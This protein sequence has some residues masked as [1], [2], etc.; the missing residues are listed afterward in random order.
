MRKFIR[1][2]NTIKYLKAKQIFYRIYYLFRNRFVSILSPSLKPVKN[3]KASN[4]DAHTWID[5][6]ETF[7]APS[8]FTFIGLSHTFAQ[9]KIDWNYHDLGK[10]WNYNLTYFDFLLQKS[11]TKEQGLKL[12]K[13]FMHY[14]ESIRGKKMPFPISLRTV[15]FIKFLCKYQ[16]QDQ[17]IEDFVYAEYRVLLQNIEYHILGNHLLENGFSLL[18][19]AYYFHDEQLYRHATNILYEELDEQILEDGAHFE[20]SPMYHQIMLHRLLDIINLLE[21]NKWKEDNLLKFLKEKASSML[22]WL[23]VISYRNGDLPRLNDT[24]E[25]IAPNNVVL[26]KY[27]KDLHISWQKSQLGA[28]G[29]RKRERDR[30]ECLVDI[31]NIGPDYI[32]GHA[33]SDIGHFELYIDGSPLLVDTGL[34]TYE[35][36]SIREYE[37]SAFAHN[38]VVIN[39]K[40]QSQMWGGFRVA[41]RAHVVNTKEDRLSILVTHDAYKKEGILHTRSW[42][43]EEKSIII[44]DNIDGKKASKI[45]SF[46]HFHPNVHVDLTNNIIETDKVRIVFKGIKNIYMKRYDY[47]LGFNKR[48]ESMV[49]ILETDFISTMEIIIK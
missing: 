24:A 9:N 18:F 27:A 3:I 45:T 21:H 19:G 1:I 35:N 39:Q 46:L 38:T 28:S 42:F 34:S 11:M 22:S 29:Y 43:F 23:E 44:K 41:N 2:L 31:G 7:E 30:Y 13:S 15:N 26:Y 5:A 48:V 40:D 20:L 37:R 47:A 25:S 16:I 36:N 8:T 17:E 4:I 12:I 32:P 14:P 33:H 49:A 6:Y 10:L